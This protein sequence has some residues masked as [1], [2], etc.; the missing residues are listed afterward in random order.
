MTGS[1]M[2]TSVGADKNTC[3]QNFCLGISGN[4]PLQS[5]DLDK[6]NVKRAYELSDGDRS[7]DDK[8]RAT[9]W[10][11]QVI[12]EAIDEADIREFDGRVVVLIGTGLRELRSL[13]L[14]WVDQTPMHIRELHFGG[15]VR[16]ECGMSVPVM[17]ISNACAASNY[18][19]GI[20]TDMLALDEADI[21]IVAGVDSIT[22]SMFGL[23]DRVNPNNPEIVQPLDDKRQ[24]VLMGEG[25]AA[26][27]LETTKHARARGKESSITIRSVGLNCDAF[28][29]T[30]PDVNGIADAMR[31]A[32]SRAEVEPKE[33]DVII[34][35]GT[36]TQLNDAAEVKAINEVF[37]Q[38][39]S[40]PHI[41][42][43][44]SIIG[45]TSGASG[46]VGVVAAAECIRQSRIP[47]TLGLGTPME[48][49][50]NLNIVQGAAAACDVNL[51]QINAFGFGGVNAVVM[52]E[53]SNNG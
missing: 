26:I 37:G 52:M 1:A 24:G 5:F 47:P 29:E 46:L 10:L 53:G 51:A 9:K 19:L 32:H 45:H 7:V 36:G 39:A 4:K 43:L 38:H 25:A 23:L 50:K 15:A 28:H 13:E 11:C 20:A 34:N 40:R 22:E 44:K 6:F 14:W 48:E 2:L 35:H 33:I 31:D 17:T 12:N 41:S 30:A 27:V 16:S 21:V 49:A 18:A 3:F 42:A 8:T